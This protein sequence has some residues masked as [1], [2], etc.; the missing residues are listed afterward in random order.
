MQPN[1]IGP[2]DIV[3]RI[4]VGGMGTVYRAVYQ[5]TGQKVAIK[6]LSPDL[7]ANEKLIARF[8][9]EMAILKKLQNPYIVRYFGSGRSAAQ[10]YCVMELVEGG[11]LADLLREKKRL[12][13]EDVIRI[14]VQICEALEHA[15]HEG[16]VHRDLK[17]ANLMLNKDGKLKLTDFGIARDN[18]AT[19]LTAAGRTVGTY[20][21]MPPEQISGKSPISIKTDLYAL[22]CVLFELLTG[23]PP[24]EADSDV[25]LLYKHLQEEP[26]RVMSLAMDCPV[27]LESVIMRLLEKDPE[28]RPRD[29]ASVQMSLREVEEK[30][31]RQ[32]SVAQHTVTGGPTTL[33]VDEDATELIKLLKSDTRKRKKKRKKKREQVPVY[34]Q[35]WFL[36]ACLLL[37]IGGVTWALWPPSEQELFASAQP[38]MESDQPYQWKD[39]QMMYLEPL[40][41]RFPDGEYADRAREFIDKVAVHEVERRTLT[42]LK[43]GGEP[44][45]E[46]ERLLVEAWKFEQFGDRVTALEK[47]TSMVELLKDRDDDRAYVMLARK[48]IREIEESG[49]ETTDRIEIVT[50]ALDRAEQLYIDGR[51]LE[52]RKTWNSIVALYASNQEMVPQVEQAR[53]RLAG[54]DPKPEPAV[55]PEPATQ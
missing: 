44:K 19:A 3:E 28:K 9:R 24:F 36:V 49:T 8:E 40:L 47:Y 54:Q 33:A 27:W 12:P 43:L 16:I 41:E 30:V 37:L 32:A 50:A 52:A 23:R 34:E 1:S 48:N 13:W 22:G 53:A 21:Y 51:T 26:P 7:A 17:P 45:S 2:F 15:H 25:N 55:A 38:L 10:R 46:A 6:V 29:A 39:A 11:T 4:G 5:K 18:T 42:N 14:G 35:S 31:A 20:A